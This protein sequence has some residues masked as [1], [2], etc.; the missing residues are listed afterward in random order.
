MVA[1]FIVTA[2]LAITSYYQLLLA[3]YIIIC[4]LCER[5]RRESS[6]TISGKNFRHLVKHTFSW[7]PYAAIH[8]SIP[9]I[10]LVPYRLLQV[11]GVGTKAENFLILLTLVVQPVNHGVPVVS[12][13]CIDFQL[14]YVPMVAIVTEIICFKGCGK[15][16][17]KRRNLWLNFGLGLTP[18]AGHVNA[19]AL[20]CQELNYSKSDFMNIMPDIAARIAGL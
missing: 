1:I 4:G 2:P 16:A 9:T 18:F 6:G 7:Q 8:S 3:K 11:G 14:G 15:K 13:I 19:Y 20:G 12:I 17:L 10:E 5:N